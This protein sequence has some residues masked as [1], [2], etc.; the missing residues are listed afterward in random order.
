MPA[1]L[2]DVPFKASLDG[3]TVLLD[4]AP[5]AFVTR[6]DAMT[7]AM[8]HARAHVRKGGEAYVSVE[9]ADGIWRLFNPDLTA[10][11]TS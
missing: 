9:G 4:G 7:F 1:L 2:L 8:E 11:L 10:P 6:L 5:H 3:F